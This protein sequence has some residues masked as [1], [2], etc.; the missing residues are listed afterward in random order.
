[1]WTVECHVQNVGYILSFLL[2]NWT[3]ESDEHKAS[4]RALINEVQDFVADIHNVDEMD[5]VALH[6]ELNV[7]CDEPAAV[8]FDREYPNVQIPPINTPER[9]RLNKKIATRAIHRKLNVRWM[10]RHKAN[11]S[12]VGALKH[13]NQRGLMDMEGLEWMREDFKTVE[14][15]IMQAVRATMLK[16]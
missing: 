7:R 11:A 2:Y 16:D 6:Y 13:W 8:E 4:R 9:A 15:W 3:D 12:E 5:P 10:Q 1:M 14:A